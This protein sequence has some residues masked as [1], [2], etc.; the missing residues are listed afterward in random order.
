MQEADDRYA[1]LFP[2]EARLRNLTYSTEIY[3]NV[4]MRTLK[5]DTSAT[6]TL[7]SGFKNLALSENPERRDIVKEGDK[8]YRVT[9]EFEPVRVYLGKVPVMVRSKFC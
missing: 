9:K 8:V 4:S 2:H 7:T 1:P 3:V 6:D 5:L